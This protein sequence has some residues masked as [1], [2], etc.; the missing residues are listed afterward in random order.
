MRHPPI[1]AP[2]E[3]RQDAPARE[4]LERE[5]GQL[6]EN[7]RRIADRQAGLIVTRKTE[8]QLDG[9]GGAE[10]CGGNDPRIQAIRSGRTTAVTI[11]PQQLRRGLRT[12]LVRRQQHA[13]LACAL[14]IDVWGHLAECASELLDRRGEWMPAR[15]RLH[16]W[17]AAPA[18]R[19]RRQSAVLAPHAQPRIARP[20][21][22]E[23][24]HG[25][26]CS[27]IPR[28]VAACGLAPPGEPRC[29][30]SGRLSVRLLAGLAAV[31]IDGPKAVGKTATALRRAATVYR[32]DN[33]AERSIVEAD[34]SRLLDG[35]RPIL[36]D[37][38]QRP[39]ESFDRSAEQSTTGPN[40]GAS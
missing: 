23:N 24:D 9:V 20:D 5:L 6:S 29:T 19:A 37:E 22:V 31:A 32:L 7:P 14:R 28:T 21:G 35:Q 33:D 30:R 2:G 27:P 8:Q 26:T 4:Q 25:Q 13:Q 18:R 3:C 11:G 16:R 39:P 40:R 36:I 1:L 34:P 17:P 15:T 38:W 10:P 12:V